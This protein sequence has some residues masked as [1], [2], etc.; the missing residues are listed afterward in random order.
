MVESSSGFI[1]G[2]S[3]VRGNEDDVGFGLK[4]FKRGKISK[5]FY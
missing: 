1:I 5:F 4:E 3:F 2:R